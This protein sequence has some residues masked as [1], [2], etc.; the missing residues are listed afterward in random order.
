MSIGPPRGRTPR[1]PGSYPS[2]K[3]RWG[4][5][6]R[7]RSGVAADAPALELAIEGLS[8]EAQASGRKCLV[9]PDG[10]KHA[11]DVA[12]LDVFERRQVLGIVAGDRQRRRLVLPD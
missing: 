3:P 4:R 12:P 2:A 1:N 6:S 10:G 5:M 9:A 7:L 11:E 8:I